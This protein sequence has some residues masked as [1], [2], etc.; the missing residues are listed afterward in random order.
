MFILTGQSNARGSGHNIDANPSELGLQDNVKIWI[1]GS[2]WQTLNIGVNNRP[3][4]LDPDRHGFELGFAQEIK[5]YYPNDEIYLIKYA[6]G[7]TFMS[8][9]LSG[10]VVYEE[11]WNN[12]VVPSIN[13]LISNDKFPY[14]NMIMSQGE[15]DST[16]NAL[17]LDYVNKLNT[18]VNLW[19]SNIGSNIGIINYEMKI[20]NGNS[21]SINTDWINKAS[22]DPLHTSLD[23]KNESDVGDNVHYDYLGQKSIASKGTIALK[24]FGGQQITDLL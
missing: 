1:K 10:G 12:Y 8:E 2:G 7:G 13:N 4:D 19:R 3:S 9:H 17:T 14:V 18:W 11:L 6:I 22:S 5:T 20:S 24:Q 15:N 23:T 21:A 16:D